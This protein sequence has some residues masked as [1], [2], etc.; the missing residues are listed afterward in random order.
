M[1][2]ERK[3][4]AMVTL[5]QQ[6]LRTVG[7]SLSGHSPVLSGVPEGAA[8]GV[9]RAVSHCGRGRDVVDIM[10]DVPQ[11]IVL[12]ADEIR[13]MRTALNLFHRRLA[14]ADLGPDG[15]AEMARVDGLIERLS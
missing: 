6:D 1:R 14:A 5:S 11:A 4:D 2:K 9:I 15:T 8:T 12:D 13:T 3:D 7:L 10:T